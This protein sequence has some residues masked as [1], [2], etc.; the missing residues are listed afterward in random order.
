[1]VFYDVGNSIEDNFSKIPYIKSSFYFVFIRHLFFW[2]LTIKESL[3]YV[4][5]GA[6]F[7]FVK[8]FIG[9][10]KNAINCSFFLQEKFTNNLS[11]YC[12]YSYFFDDKAI[13]L[14]LLKKMHPAIH[15][16]SRTHGFETYPNQAPFEH[17]PFQKFKLKYIDKIMPVS[18]NGAIELKKI[19]NKFSSKIEVHYLGSLNHQNINSISNHISIVSCAYIRSIKRLDKV[20][21]ILK[22]IEKPIEWTLIGDGEDLNKIKKLANKLP[23]NITVNFLGELTK[24]EIYN[25]YQT[26]P[27]TL[28]LSV[29]ETEGL[30]V[31]IME[32]ISFGVPVIA[33][34]VGG[35]SEIVTNETGILISKNLDY[36]KIANLILGFEHTKFGKPENR[37]QIKEFWNENFNATTNYNKFINTINA[38]S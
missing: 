7:G 26:K 35:C 2:I 12:F 1:M 24:N 30:P 10:V 13:V 17:I 27:F 9:S 33:T 22:L 29:S 8:Y 38:I 28:F 4:K 6:K 25:L 16:V 31:S 36:E 19:N 14:A 21:D 34:N 18:Y 5:K 32:A 3:I 20:I 11:E 23:Q 15:V 37:K